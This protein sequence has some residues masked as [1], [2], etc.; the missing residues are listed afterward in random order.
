MI[1]RD[2]QYEH[3]SFLFR[4]SRKFV[5]SDLWSYRLPWAK[6]IASLSL[7]KCICIVKRKKK[8]K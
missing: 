5:V 2:L 7:A 3:T 1:A 4:I 8:K 6:A